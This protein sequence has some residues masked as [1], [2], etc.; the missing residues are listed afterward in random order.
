MTVFKNGV[1]IGSDYYTLAGDVLTINTYLTVG[2]N[3][4]I[5]TQVASNVVNVTSGYGDSNVAAFLTTNTGNIS[6]GYFI[7][8][9]SQLTGLP[10]GY[11]DSNVV[12]LLSSGSVS[13]EIITT[14]NITGD[15]IIGNGSQLTGLPASYANTNVNTYLNSGLFTGNFIPNGN[16]TQSLGNSTNQWKDLWISGNTLYMTQVPISLTG[17][18]TLQV[19][20]AN[21]VTSTAGGNIN[22]VGNVNA[23]G[24]TITGNAI[25]TGNASIQGT[26]TFNNTTS[27]TTSNLVLGLGN[28]QSGI[29]VTGGGIVVGNTAEAQ[30][31]YDQPN[32]TWDSNLGITATGN[33]TAPYF[34]GDGSQLTGLPASYSN[35]NV[36]TLLASG[37]VTSNVITT[38]N[39]SGNYILG[40]GAFLTG[41]FGTE[42]YLQ[43]GRITT[44]QAGVGLNTDLIFNSVTAQSG[45][46]QISLNTTTGVVSLKA[47]VTYNLTASP[48][49][50]IFTNT[51][52]GFLT[53]TWV[54][55]VTNTPLVAGIS[56]ASTPATLTSADANQQLVS[57]VYTP[58]T[59]Q[60]VKVRV[61][62]ASGTAGLRTDFSFLS[63]TQIGVSAGATSF[64]NLTVTGNTTSGNVSATDI[65]ANNSLIALSDVILGNTAN[66]SATKT[67]IVS[68]AANSF[69]QTGNGTA[70]TTGNIVFSTYST[71]NARVVI[72]TTSGNVSAVGNV[73]ANYFIGNGSQ[74]T[75]LTAGIPNWT[76]AGTIQS[77]GLTATVSSP[78]LAT[79]PAKNQVYYKQIGPK[80]WQVSVI[81]YQ[82]S[83]PGAAIGSGDYIFTLPGGLQFDTSIQFQNIYN[84][85]PG[86]TGPVLY[87]FAIPGSTFASSV[88]TTISTGAICVYSATQYRVAGTVPGTDTRFIGSSWAQPQSVGMSWTWSFTFQTP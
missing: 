1:L 18:N 25:I 58:S 86:T 72:N 87:A 80:T 6:A 13:S 9:G 56:G 81:Y 88:S 20:G 83:T 33:I 14:G 26:L 17:A 31:T 73:S 5:I 48:S 68:F 60:T 84:T 29:N 11:T 3:I 62:G 36:T 38:G 61:L 82:T 7:G 69:I 34:I 49:F 4:N 44:S 77:V 15:Y 75:G 10:A 22:A 16:A 42:D 23:G 12:A 85:V 43:A 65:V 40:N 74:L 76:A 27:I 21:V 46:S 71:D 8:D 39:I 30:F 37:T 63:V 64:T 52:S 51:T 67:R 55:A 66:A 28:N 57:V 59:N 24:M 41:I 45:T 2:D 78:S 54:D 53:Y 47:G 50:G 19:A 70:G 35:A 32:Q 79:S